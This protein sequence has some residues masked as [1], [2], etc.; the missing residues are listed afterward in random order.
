VV[1]RS[2]AQVIELR[3]LRVLGHHGVGEDERAV[4]QPFEVDLDVTVDAE[5]AASTD[6]VSDT[7]DYGVLAEE[8]AAVVS[9]RSFRLLEA[10]GHQIAQVV[11][12]HERVEAVTVTVR[13]LRPPVPVDLATAAV[14]VTCCRQP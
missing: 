13:K 3:G 14:K 1:V 11:L 10:L 12:C 6:D 4:A 9:E 2:T 7:V 8:V 5:Q